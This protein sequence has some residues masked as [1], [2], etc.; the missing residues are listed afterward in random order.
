MWNSTKGSTVQVI[1]TRKKHNALPEIEHAQC[2]TEIEPPPLCTYPVWLLWKPNTC[3]PEKIL[4]PSNPPIFRSLLPIC[5][6]SPVSS[7][8][9]FPLQSVKYRL[10]T[11]LCYPTS[12]YV[13]RSVS[14]SW[15]PTP[16]CSAIAADTND[17]KRNI[18]LLLTES[19]ALIHGNFLCCK[20][21]VD[22]CC[23]P[24]TVP[25]CHTPT[26]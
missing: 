6:A 2:V 23:A 18:T 20:W 5:L 13:T 26:L 8:Y 11:S 17:T 25:Q 22:I 10:Q 19:L 9:T 4:T 1:R 21:R 16:S 15:L 7:M 12:F 14:Y 3:D 24:T